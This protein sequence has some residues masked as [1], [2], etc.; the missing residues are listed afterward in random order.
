MQSNKERSCYGEIE[1]VFVALLLEQSLSLYWFKLQVNKDDCFG[2]VLCPLLAL[3]VLCSFLA[4]QILPVENSR[5]AHEASLL[6][7]VE[8]DQEE[9]C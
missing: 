3:N 2:V 8:A 1:L 6:Q 4:T 5:P 7:G 9:P